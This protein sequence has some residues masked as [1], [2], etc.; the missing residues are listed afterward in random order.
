MLVVTNC[1]LAD[2][3]IMF[4][5]ACRIEQVALGYCDIRNVTPDVLEDL[6]SSLACLSF[7]N[8]EVLT[9]HHLAKLYLSNKNVRFDHFYNIIIIT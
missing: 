9:G 2:S 3:D 4:L 5:K 7:D 8:W 1:K 6:A